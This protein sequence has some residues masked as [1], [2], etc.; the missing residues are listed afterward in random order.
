MRTA[1]SSVADAQATNHAMSLGIALALAACPIALSSGDL[2]AVEH[3]V[4]MLLGDSTR[5]AL[6]LFPAWSR[7][8]QAV[9][10]IR[11]GDLVTGLQLLRAG[12]DELGEPWTASRF[13]DFLTK[14]AQAFRTAWHV[15]AGLATTVAPMERSGRPAIARERSG[16]LTDPVDARVLATRRLQ[17]RGRPSTDEWVHGVCRDEPSKRPGPSQFAAEVAPRR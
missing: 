7:C 16:P 5:H 4:E 8:H 12:L 1:E 11:R 6:P 14:M 15:A 10:V 9:L 2:A 3:Y 17:P 13:R